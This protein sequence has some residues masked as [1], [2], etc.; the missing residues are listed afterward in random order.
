M[1]K[2]I[3]TLTALALIACSCG[4][5]QAKTI[6]QELADVQDTVLVVS[7]AQQEQNMEPSNEQP[8]EDYN[9]INV[10]NIGTY[11]EDGLCSIE[12]EIKENRNF[13][14][15]E[16]G[17]VTTRGIYEISQNEENLLY[18]AFS[19]ISAIYYNDTIDIQNY[20]NA[21]N[22]YIH[23]SSCDQKYLTFIR[24]QQNK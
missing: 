10:I 16:T 15:I 9:K 1:K 4:N 8:D 7:M 5:R 24:M 23:F 18:V 20:G 3:I 21:M 11:R 17:K 22:E 6:K 13:L 12:I 2:I 19:S 14:I